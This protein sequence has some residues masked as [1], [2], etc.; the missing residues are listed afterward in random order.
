MFSLMSAPPVSRVR[1]HLQQLLSGF[2]WSKSGARWLIGKLG[3]STFHPK[4]N[5]C[6]WS[7]FSPSKTISPK[8]TFCN[9]KS[10][11]KVIFLMYFE[12]LEAQISKLSFSRVLVIF[13]FACPFQKCQVCKI[14]SSPSK[15]PRA[16]R[17][18]DTG[19]TC[20]FTKNW[21]NAPKFSKFSYFD[22]R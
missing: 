17:G 20:N 22:T 19:K 3:L 16:R 11:Q 21:Q 13:L 1:A 12:L 10:G 18:R 8:V 4:W 6:I 7:C 14:P 15:C 5:F 9:S 2:H